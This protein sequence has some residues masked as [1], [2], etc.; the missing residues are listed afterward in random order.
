M[1]SAG[2]VLYKHR[3]YGNARSM[4]TTYKIVTYQPR[5]HIFNNICKVLQYQTKSPKISTVNAHVLI[6]FFSHI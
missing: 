5:I 6:T 1:H 4:I 3:L 2:I